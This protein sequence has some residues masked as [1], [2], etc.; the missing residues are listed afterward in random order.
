MMTGT[1]SSE[2][3]PLASTTLMVTSVAPR[4]KTAVIDHDA[5]PEQVPDPVV[6]PDSE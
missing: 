2:A 1:I 4:A 3:L 6:A 5:R